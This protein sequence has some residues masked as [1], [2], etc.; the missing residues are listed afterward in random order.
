MSV[1]WS[2]EFLDSAVVNI[3]SV[4][5]HVDLLLN[6]NSRLLN[7]RII[8]SW[9]GLLL[10]MQNNFICSCALHSS[11]A[12]N[13]HFSP[14]HGPTLQFFIT[15][16]RVTLILRLWQV[17]FR[18]PVLWLFLVL[19]Y[20]RAAS[21][22][23]MCSFS[24]W[25][26]TIAV[27]VLWGDKMVF[28]SSADPAGISTKTT[29]RFDACEFWTFHEGKTTNLLGTQ[30]MSLLSL[31]KPHAWT[32]LGLTVLGASL[33]LPSPLMQ[34]RSSSSLYLFSIEFLSCYYRL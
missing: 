27:W 1:S 16:S 12:C 26:L 30:G 7:S 9:W 13:L 8:L 19:M 6:S 14:C 4:A 29:A 2:S 33:A 10:A 25:H 17:K 31:R 11:A 28:L 5:P 32:V 34:F 21:F 20:L 15:T 18:L 3:S 23:A 22:S 24:R